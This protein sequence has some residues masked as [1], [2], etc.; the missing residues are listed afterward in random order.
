MDDIITFRPDEDTSRAL[1]ILDGR[2][3]TVSAAVRAE[4]IDARER[5]HSGQTIVAGRTTR[6]LAE[7]VAADSA[8]AVCRGLLDIM[9]LIGA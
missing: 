1:S 5:R 9:Y 2:R 7:Q 3:C 4:L 8:D 6:V